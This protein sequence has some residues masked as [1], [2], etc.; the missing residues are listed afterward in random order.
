MRLTV[1]MLALALV[2]ALASGCTGNSSPPGQSQGAA[3]AQGGQFSGVALPEGYSLDNDRSIAL[4]AGDRWVGRIS[5]TSGTS[6]NEMFDFYR[7][8][9][10]KYGWVEGTVVRGQSN[11]ITFTSPATSRVAV[12]QITSLTLGGSRVEMVVSPQSENGAEAPPMPGTSPPGTVTS[13][14]LH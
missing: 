14:P 7:R 4:G 6:P 12:V 8:E 1:T 9:M 11:L 2:A 5:F 10:P 13:Q 3:T